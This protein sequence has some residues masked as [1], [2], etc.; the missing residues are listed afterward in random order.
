MYHLKKDL[1]SSEGQIACGSLYQTGYALTLE[2][3]NGAQEKRKCLKCAGMAIKK[4]RTLAK[5]KFVNR[6][7]KQDGELFDTLTFDR[8]LQSLKNTYND[9]SFVENELLS[10]R[11]IQTNFMWYELQK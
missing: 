4:M 5:S 6:F 8:A 11:R 2:D 9:M 10:G 3:F 1:Q 7:S